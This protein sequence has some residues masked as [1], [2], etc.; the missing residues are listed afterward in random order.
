MERRRGFKGSRHFSEA[1]FGDAG[2]FAARRLWPSRPCNLALLPG[3]C[4]QLLPS[5]LRGP[6][7]APSHPLAHPGS[8]A[9]SE[10][11]MGTWATGSS[12]CVVLTP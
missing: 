9:A 7:T 5:S 3:A 10:E 2:L 8:A 1:L 12:C 4:S 6:S 11:T